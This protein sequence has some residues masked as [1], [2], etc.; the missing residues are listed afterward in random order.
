MAIGVKMA[1]MGDKGLCLMAIESKKEHVIRL[2]HIANPISTTTIQKLCE[3][4]NETKIKF[5][6]TELQ[7]RYEMVSN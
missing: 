5:P 7:I 2:H 6:G 4:L 1:P 3:E